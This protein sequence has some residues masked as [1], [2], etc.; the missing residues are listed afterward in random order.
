MYL[1]LHPFGLNREVLG[2]IPANLVEK[3]RQLPIE[4]LESLGEA[5]LD[6][7]SEADLVN[8]LESH[9]FGQPE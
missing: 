7:Q 4:T 6:F 9:S 2:V 3:I 5:L 1:S 8:W